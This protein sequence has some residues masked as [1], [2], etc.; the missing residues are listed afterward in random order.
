MLDDTAA[1]IMLSPVGTAR[2]SAIQPYHDNP[3]RGDTGQYVLFYFLLDCIF[4]YEEPEKPRIWPSA[5]NAFG[6]LPL[7]CLIAAEVL[8]TT[9]LVFAFCRLSQYRR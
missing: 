8:T 6:K 1:V 7:S 5:V 2:P 3:V 9:Y 4:H